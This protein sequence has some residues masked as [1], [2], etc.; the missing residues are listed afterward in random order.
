MPRATIN[1]A[2]TQRHELKT[3]E[4]G[5]V[6]LRRMSYG[7]FLD[8]QSDAMMMK[9]TGDAAGDREMDLRMMGRQTAL[10][11]FKECV[12]EHN[13]EDENGNVLDFSK[14]G[15]LDILDPRI[16][17]EIGEYLNALNSFEGRLG[18]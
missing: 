4:G 12:V 7:K 5:Y 9:V 3:L 14:P 8:R 11:E 15:T 6:V 1:P 2:D 13:L 17:Q 18:E 16:G 10:L